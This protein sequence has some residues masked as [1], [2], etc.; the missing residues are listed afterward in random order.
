MYNIVNHTHN[1]VQQI[2][3]AFHPAWLKPYSPRITTPHFSSPET[4]ASTILPSVSTFSFSMLHMCGIMQYLSFSNWPICLAKCLWGSSVSQHVTGLCSYLKGRIIFQCMHMTCFLYHLLVDE[5]LGC[6][7]FLACPPLGYYKN[8]CSG[9][10]CANIFKVLF[11]SFSYTYEKAGFLDHKVILF[12]IFWGFHVIFN[13]SCTFYLSASSEQI[14]VP[15][16]PCQQF[17]LFF[18]Q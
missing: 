12:L 9:H 1:V 6:F 13:N 14:P 11:S 18:W 16:H 8:L 15:L 4:L 10:A 3:R 5:Y 7:H 2:S 17:F